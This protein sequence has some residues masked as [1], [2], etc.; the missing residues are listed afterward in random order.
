MSLFRRP[1][2]LRRPWWERPSG[3]WPSATVGL[4]AVDRRVAREL[5]VGLGP[6]ACGHWDGLHPDGPCAVCGTCPGFDDV[7]A[8]RARLRETVAQLGAR[9][10]ET[11]VRMTAYR[12]ELA[13]VRD[14]LANA[15]RS[16]WI[17]ARDGGRTCLDCGAEIRRGEAYE[18]QPGTGGLLV[19][20]Y[21]PQLPP[22]NS[23]TLEQP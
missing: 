11:I 19:H 15:A 21:C 18:L 23:Q 17:V 14:E 13:K 8:D 6:C 4:A 10:T 9:N 12:R 1:R 5:A 7:V 20:I 16:G 22:D 3:P 2:W